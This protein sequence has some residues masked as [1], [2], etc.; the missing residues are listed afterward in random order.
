VN[1]DSV[2]VGVAMSLKHGLLAAEVLSLM[3][4][5]D[6]TLGIVG[7]DGVRH[8]VL[9]LYV[10]PVFPV[11]GE[12]SYVFPEGLLAKGIE[13]WDAPK[14]VR[15]LRLSILGEGYYYLELNP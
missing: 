1:K 10:I 13:R 14:W 5:R 9:P 8:A 2:I 12:D 6:A 3:D 4:N 15:A 11:C 7:P